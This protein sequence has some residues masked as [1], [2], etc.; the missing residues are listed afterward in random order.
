MKFCKTE[1]SAEC[2][3]LSKKSPPES[4]EGLEH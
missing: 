3:I 4:T 2:K 1:I